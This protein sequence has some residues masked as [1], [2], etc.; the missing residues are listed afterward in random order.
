MLIVL[1]AK[2]D[3]DVSDG[4]GA[5][6]WQAAPPPGEHDEEKMRSAGLPH[7]PIIPSQAA[8]DETRR[9]VGKWNVKLHTRTERL[10]HSIARLARCSGTTRFLRSGEH[11]K[12]E[13]R[14]CAHAY[15][16]DTPL[17][18]LWKEL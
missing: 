4:K 12:T 8:K 18:I 5:K 11:R 16:D 7:D 3:D 1:A 2:W 9:R 6:R 13:L 17:S 14:M 15:N 10:R